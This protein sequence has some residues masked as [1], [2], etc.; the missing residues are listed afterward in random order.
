MSPGLALF[1]IL[2]CFFVWTP[3]ATSRTMMQKS[4]EC[5]CPQQH[6]GA[7]QVFICC[8]ALKI[9]DLPMM[10]YTMGS[11]RITLS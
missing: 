4:V 5:A 10:R 1:E 3:P 6:N 11:G 8:M 7:G 9:L 2:P